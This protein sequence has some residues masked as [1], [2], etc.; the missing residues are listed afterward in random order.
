MSNGGLWYWLSD[1]LLG[2]IG[3]LVGAVLWLHNKLDDEHKKE[4]RRELDRLW[5]TIDK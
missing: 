2:L 1:H 4:V 5:E 3:L